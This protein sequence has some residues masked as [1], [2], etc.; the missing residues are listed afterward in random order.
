MRFSTSPQISTDRAS[1][2]PARLQRQIQRLKSDQSGVRR[3]AVH[4]LGQMGDPRA[5]EALSA[6]LTDA[7]R[8][9]CV[10]AALALGEIGDLRGVEILIPVLTD[11]AQHDRV[12]T[13]AA[14]ALWLLGDERAVEPLGLAAGEMS[15]YL[16]YYA[17]KALVKIGSLRAIALL[18]E[19]LQAAD[20]RQR[21]CAA[22]VLAKSERGEA[23]ALGP[24]CT[25]LQ[26]PDFSVRNY[27]AQALG[28]IGDARALDALCEALKDL[29]NDVCISAAAALGSI[30]SLEAVGPLCSLLLDEEETVR[31]AGI[32]AIKQIGRP[33]DLPLGIL[34]LAAY[35]P[36][37]KL[38]TLH[39][40][41]G[42]SPRVLRYSFVSVRTFCEEL[43]RRPDSAEP[44][45]RGAEAVLV[46]LQRRG[47][48]QT[49]LRATEREADREPTELLR[50]AIGP[51]D[52]TPPDE[53]LRSAEAPLQS[54]PLPKARFLTR[55]FRQR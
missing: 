36:I 26:D 46:E 48:A 22:E 43:L 52:P 44:A 50:G 39:I 17:M 21:Q 27:A 34:S 9:V 4:A 30:G 8:E 25:A 16:H 2:P 53:L 42:A 18:C 20:V 47:E 3:D 6:A 10:E 1:L 15:G 24:L 19:R 35:T 41:A 55:I 13:A 37:Q 14:A 11:R 7:N 23:E 49:L 40:L 28:H 31:A 54:K 5:M 38:D 33:E 45:K 29:N 12:R 51:A 32:K